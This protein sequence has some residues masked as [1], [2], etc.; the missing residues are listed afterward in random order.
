M[1]DGPVICF[2]QQPCGIFPRRFLYAKIV[3]AR[4]LQR[5]IGGRIVFFFHDADHDPRETQTFVHHRKTGEVQMLNF[6][7]ENKLQRKYSPL[8]LKRIPAGWRESTA[9][10]LPAFVDRRWVDVFKNVQADN[11]ADFCLEM[12]RGMGLLEGIEI[13]RSGSADVRRAACEIGDFFVDVPFEG[14]VV[15]ARWRD[16]AL[17]LHEGGDVYRTVP[18]VPFGKEQVSPTR[19][20][21]LRWM[22][23]VIHCTHYVS[24]MGEQAYL[25]KEDAPEIVYVTR[26]TIDRSDEAYTDIA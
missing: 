15:R 4:R 16:G 9:R 25:R 12:Y 19:D 17:Q 7:F 8:C 10:Q 20:S 18:L 3:T 11:V 1:N 24:G 5:E 14:E 2:G 26:D 21:R 22:Q 13:V 23:S 6:A